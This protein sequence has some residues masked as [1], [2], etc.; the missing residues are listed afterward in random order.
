MPR[1]AAL[2]L[3]LVLAGPALAD[4]RIPIHVTFDPEAAKQLAQMGEMVTISAH[5]YGEAKPDSTLEP[6]EMGEI[7]LGLEEF[8][9]APR[10]VTVD[11]GASLAVAPAEQVAV[12][13]LNVNVWTARYA[14]ENNLLDCGIV[15]GAVAE[16][17]GKVQEIACKLLPPDQIQ[18]DTPPPD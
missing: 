15:D 7:T 5:F 2:I 13:M 17:T 8:T 18:T 12:P 1:A 6:D 11:T 4:S 3:P 16:L 9:V 10:D 14:D